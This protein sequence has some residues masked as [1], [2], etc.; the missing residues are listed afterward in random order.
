MTERAK[1]LVF[2]MWKL[3]TAVR[4]G[5]KQR[6]YTVKLLCFTV[7]N[8]N[9][10]KRLQKQSVMGKRKTGMTKSK[11]RVGALCIDYAISEINYFIY[12]F[13]YLFL[14]EHGN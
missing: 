12:K 7:W 1:L 3:L 11:M 5:S 4:C 6:G 14:K 9:S 13:L 10:V 8:P 2:H